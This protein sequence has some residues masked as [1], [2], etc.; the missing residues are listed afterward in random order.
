MKWILLCLASLALVFQAHC[1]DVI[2]RTNG[3]SIE[4]KITKETKNTVY[5]NVQRNGEVVAT[6]L[7]RGKISDITYDDA[8]AEVAKMD[9][10]VVKRGNGK[11]DIYQ[12]GES[13]AFYEVADLMKSKPL[14]HKEIKR[15][16]S[17]RIVA[18]TFGALGGAGIGWPIGT[19]LAGGEPQWLFAAAGL[20]AIVLSI[21]FSQKSNEKTKKAVSLYNGAPATS[22][23]WD[24]KELNLTTTG[25]GVGLILSF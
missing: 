14:A 6:S 17:N 24:Q 18:S 23:F 16:K 20:G 8:P 5:F 1:Q 11:Y 7:S 3:K 21:P 9:S 22:S 10:L 13:L 12:G 25:S 4:C 15:A 19:A 2:Q